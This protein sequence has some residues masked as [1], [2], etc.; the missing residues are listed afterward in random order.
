MS[1]GYFEGKHYR[2]R[3][4]ECRMV[5][6]V[7]ATAETRGTNQ[8]FCYVLSTEMLK[9]AANYERM[10]RSRTGLLVTLWSLRCGRCDDAP[11]FGAW[12]ACARND[13]APRPR[14]YF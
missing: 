10:A 2:K 4:E 9:V 13:F 5:A 6:R 7:L 3:A 14:S 8:Q 11:P 1:D 12:P